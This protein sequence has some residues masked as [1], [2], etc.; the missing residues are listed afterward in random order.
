MIWWAGE[1][2]AGAKIGSIEQDAIFVA[3][4][5]EEASDEQV[6]LLSSS[7]T[8]SHHFDDFARDLIFA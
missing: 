5:G 4:A 1:G 8:L 2:L 3:F 7:A 6:I